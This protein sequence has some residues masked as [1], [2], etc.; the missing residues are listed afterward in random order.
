MQIFPK[1]LNAKDKIK[2]EIK[3]TGKVDSKYSDVFD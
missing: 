2:S 3:N 1:G